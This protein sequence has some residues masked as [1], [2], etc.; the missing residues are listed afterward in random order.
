MKTNLSVV[1]ARTRFSACLRAVE[2]G[3]SLVI[4]RNGKAVAA[5]VPPKDLS[6]LQALR[7]AGPDAGL[8]GLAGGW[9]GSEELADI[10]DASKRAGYS[11]TSDEA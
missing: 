6:R 3:Q 10:L 2:A 11:A 7:A 9:E 8:A 4:T 1:E 5:V